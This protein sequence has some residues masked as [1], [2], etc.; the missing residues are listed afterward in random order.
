M[1][2]IETNEWVETAIIG[3]QLVDQTRPYSHQIHVPKPAQ[4]NFF[5][6]SYPGMCI[7]QSHLYIAAGKTVVDMIVVCSSRSCDLVIYR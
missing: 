4:F 7:F 3:R 6:W 2:Y 1:L 5:C